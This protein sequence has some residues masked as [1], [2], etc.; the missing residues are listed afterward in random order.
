L[1][2][3]IHIIPEPLI[4]A[5]QA[6]EVDP[7]ATTAYTPDTRQVDG[8][9]APPSEQLP[10]PK[11]IATEAVAGFR[12]AATAFA[13]LTQPSWHSLPSSVVRAANN[14]VNNGQE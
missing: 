10:F 11:P 4:G 7:D 12:P 1:D 13:F 2:L 6:I 3:G 8:Q 14:M 9:W 5:Q